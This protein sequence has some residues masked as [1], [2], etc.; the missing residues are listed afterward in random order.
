M[1]FDWH[2]T[3]SLLKS[4]LRILGLILLLESLI[5][6]VLLLISAEIIGIIEEL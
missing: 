1:N 4:I 6:A 5:I 2:K 3:F